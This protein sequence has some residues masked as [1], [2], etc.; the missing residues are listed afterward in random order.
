MIGLLASI[1]AGITTL[2]GR[3]TST[4]AGYLDNLDAAI[5]TRAAA[6]TAL[7][8][9]TWTGTRAGYLDKIGI[10]SI[11]TGYVTLAISSAAT[12]NASTTLSTTLTDTSKAFMLL[13]SV[14]RTASGG[15]I[16][17]ENCRPSITNTTTV[18]VDWAAPDG[19]TSTIMTARIHY[20]V[21]EFNG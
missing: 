8:S 1:K 9:A 4:R 12:G 13:T 15:G 10:R 19:T 6:S 16:L 14:E 3:L 5:S 20:L 17:L 7:S 18:R 2:T 11:Q 21:V